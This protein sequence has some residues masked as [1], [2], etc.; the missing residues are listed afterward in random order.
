[1]PRSPARPCTWPQGCPELVEGGGRCPDH[2]K[3]RRPTAAK[4]GYDAHWQH[5]RAAQLAATPHCEQPACYQLATEVDHIDGLG[6]KGPRGHDLMNLQ[7]LCKSHHSQRTARDQ[8]GG[9]NQR[10]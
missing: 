9:W 6:P 5:T 8:P 3:D 4:R 1:M 10:G 7:S 2:S